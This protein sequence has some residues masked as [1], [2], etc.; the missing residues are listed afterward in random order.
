MKSPSHFAAETKRGERLK[1]SSR[2]FCFCKRNRKKH[3]EGGADGEEGNK[4]IE[5][6]KQEYTSRMQTRDPCPWDTHGE[7]GK[8]SSEG[9]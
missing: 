5:A 1:N 2:G 3:N 8:H 9:R 4:G 7:K 6:T